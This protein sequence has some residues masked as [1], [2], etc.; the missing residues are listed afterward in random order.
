ML[1]MFVLPVYRSASTACLQ[2]T[3]F[4]SSIS[5]QK[6]KHTRSFLKLFSSCLCFSLSAPSPPSADIHPCLRLSRTNKQ[7]FRLSAQCV[8]LVSVS[9]RVGKM[10][11]R[12]VGMKALSGHQVYLTS[13]INPPLTVKMLGRVYVKDQSCKCV[14]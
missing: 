5:K 13:A 1:S 14:Y 11:W 3:I 2:L 6:H 12:G 7:C 10:T 4:L 9:G 8:Q